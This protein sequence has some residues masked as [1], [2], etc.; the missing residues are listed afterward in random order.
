MCEVS[1]CLPGCF[2]DLELGLVEE[3][4]A[5][6]V[7]RHTWRAA[8]VHSGIRAH[9]GMHGVASWSYT[10]EQPLSIS[11]PRLDLFP[12]ESSV[13]SFSYGLGASSQTQASCSL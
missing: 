3:P 8:S 6:T 13:G 1:Q 11:V 2:M 12:S 5:G 4:E 9:D 7:T 10:V